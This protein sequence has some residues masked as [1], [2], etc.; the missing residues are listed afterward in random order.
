MRVLLQRGE[1]DITGAYG[2]PDN[3]KITVEAAEKEA[4]KEGDKES[5]GEK[6]ESPDKDDEKK[7]AS[8][9]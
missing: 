5:A 7:P 6:K 3:T 9:K 2:L 8:E 1:V 4:P